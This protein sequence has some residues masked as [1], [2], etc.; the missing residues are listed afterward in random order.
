M[1]IPL[2]TVPARTIQ[3]R[4][5]NEAKNERF[6]KTARKCSLVA[7]DCPIFTIRLMASVSILVLCLQGHYDIHLMFLQSL[8]TKIKPSVL[9]PRAI[10][11]GYFTV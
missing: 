7:F 6:Y 5:Q 1:V 2:S 9:V 11:R 8:A 4:S 10:Y 3:F